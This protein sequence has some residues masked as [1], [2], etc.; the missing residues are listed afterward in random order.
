MSIGRKNMNSFDKIFDFIVEAEGFYSNHVHDVGLTIYGIT[1]KWH[2]KIF[3]KFEEVNFDKEKC[4]EIAYNF[5]YENHWIKSKIKELHYPINYYVMDFAVNAGKKRA[6]YTLQRAINSFMPINYGD[7]KLQKIKVDGIIGER[8]TIPTVNILLDVMKCRFCCEY[9]LE[10]IEFYTKL[11]KFKFF[12][13]G[14]LNR[15]LKLINKFPF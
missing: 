8:E 7:L 10:R 12:G 5:Y 4:K 3:K 2:P 1:Q 11:K 13:K 15:I 9:L 6:I 14:W